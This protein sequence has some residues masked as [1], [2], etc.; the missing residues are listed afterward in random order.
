MVSG[1][2]G[3]LISYSIVYPIEMVRNLVMI[4]KLP[5]DI[6]FFQAYRRLLMLYGPIGQFKGLGLLAFE[7]VPYF[8]IQFTCFECLQ[9]FLKTRKNKE[10]LS[11]A[12]NLMA[13]S[14]SSLTALLLTYPLDLVRRRKSVEIY[15]K[16]NSKGY[17]NI[18]RN[19]WVK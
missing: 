2:L 10:F 18:F 1:A 3:S 15:F 5:K 9:E 17:L 11:N 14:L 7:N 19:I 8:A 13:G 4:N 16:K 12:D 6:S